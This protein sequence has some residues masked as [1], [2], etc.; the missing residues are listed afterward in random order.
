MIDGRSGLA[1]E[2]P[3]LRPDPTNPPGA[4]G[5]AARA[6]DLTTGLRQF[7]VVV[8]EYPFGAPVRAMLIRRGPRRWVGVARDL[9]PIARAEA[10]AEILAELRADPNLL[11]HLVEAPSR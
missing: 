3:E 6:A 11:F 2:G 9:H 10:L 7:R 4:A 1:G 8:R 5:A